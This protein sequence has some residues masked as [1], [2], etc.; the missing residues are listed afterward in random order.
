[1]KVTASW[2]GGRRFRCDTGSGHTALTE[3]PAPAGEGRAPSPVEMVL[4]GLAACTAI[5]VVGIL[6]RMRV[7]PRSLEVLA[8]AERAE[9]HPRVFT[10]I[11]LVYRVAGEVPREKLERAVALS[12][13]TYCSVGAM[14]AGTATITHELQIL[15]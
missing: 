10:R 4:A 5:D 1:M 15:P 7:P 8:E 12:E 14:L 3:A 6:E 11:H 13:R 9:K 2:T